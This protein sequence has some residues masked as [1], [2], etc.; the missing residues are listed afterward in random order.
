[1]RAAPR[2]DPDVRRYRIRLPPRVDGGEAAEAASRTRDARNDTP[3]RLCVRD[4]APRRPFPLAAPLP[5][6]D[7]AGCRPL[8][9]RFLGTMRASDFP[10]S[11]VSGVRGVPFPDRSADPS[12]ADDVGTS[13]FPC[14]EF[15][16][17]RRVFDCAGSAGGS[18]CAL[19]AVW[20]SASDN[21]VGIPED[22]ISQLDGWPACAPVNASAEALRPLPHDSGS[23]RLAGPSP[24]DSCI[25]DSLPVS[26]R[27]VRPAGSLAARAGGS[28][29]ARR[30]PACR[31]RS[32]RSFRLPDHECSALSC[33]G[34]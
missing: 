19:P 7:S 21:S 12:A 33:A 20:P 27:T 28:W 24:Y 9:A 13:R 25:R 34:P 15:P 16:R 6:T 5:S 14:E 1:M 8:F 22:L 29:A 2:T 11:C 26:R 3:I 4:M 18:P 10:A 31:S 23:G 17:M 32:S 30:A